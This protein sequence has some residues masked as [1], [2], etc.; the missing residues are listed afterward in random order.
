MAR[1]AFYAHDTYGL[2]H[3][4]RCLKLAGAFARRLAGV[5]GLV[6]TGTAWP[7]LF[8][9]PAGFRLVPLPPVVKSGRGTYASRDGRTSLFARLAARRRL[10]GE[11]LERFVPDLVVVD[12]VP[13]GLHREILPALRRH[14]ARPGARAVLALRD[15]LDRPAAVAAEWEQSGAAEPL[16]ELYDEVW[17]FGDTTDARRLLEGDPP[18]GDHAPFPDRQPCSRGGP[19]GEAARKL[20]PCG[21][22]G[23]ETG[24]PARSWASPR[25]GRPLVV[26]TGGGGGDAPP[27][28]R[29]YLEALRRYR[30]R[31]T[32][33]VVLGP[34]FPLR[35]LPGEAGRAVVVKAFEPRLA[36]WLEGADLVVSMAGYNTVC[37]ILE[38]GSRAVLV[39]RVWPREE[40]LIR[41]RRWG[42]AGRVRWIHP[43]DLTPAALWEAI[44]GSLAQPRPAPEVLAGGAVAAARAARLLGAAGGSGPSG[45]GRPDPNRRPLEEASAA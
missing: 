45:A 31:L 41:T 30:P 17:L 37:E 4:N 14:R 42:A 33:R 8:A 38:S 36:R 32:S 18:A 1:I 7:G 27:L 40:Q 3:L 35:E 2:G 16:A 23:R 5:E 12:N 25:R 39:P 10:I 24:G 19:L 34:D 43:R 9:P 11:A 44:E 20:R 29:S 26:V 6:L 13:C 15:V 22:L 21:R 28:V